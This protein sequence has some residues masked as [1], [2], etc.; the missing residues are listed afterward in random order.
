MLTPRHDDPNRANELKRRKAHPETFSSTRTV[1]KP[2]DWSPSTG[3]KSLD[4]RPLASDPRTEA[5]KAI[6][7]AKQKVSDLETELEGTTNKNDKKDISAA[8]D[9]AKEELA[10]LI[11]E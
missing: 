11:G 9:V 1:E 6:N 5:T 7:A 2:K 8:L 4:G 10:A 3:L